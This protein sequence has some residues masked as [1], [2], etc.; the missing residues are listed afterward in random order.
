MT[1]KDVLLSVRTISSK[2]VR[3]PDKSGDVMS[4]NNEVEVE[5]VLDLMR[6]SGVLSLDVWTGEGATVV[7][8]GLILSLG[9]V[10]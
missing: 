3:F 5:N 4:V 1:T 10:T 8:T 7:K 2:F 9:S 6:M